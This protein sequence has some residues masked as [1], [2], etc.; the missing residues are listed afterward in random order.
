MI[1][2]RTQKKFLSPSQL[3]GFLNCNYH[4]VNNLRGIKKK[5]KTISIKTLFKR[6]LKHEKDYL[7][8]IKKDKKK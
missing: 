8:K 5:E 1:K 3:I 7:A 6:G 4:T 2:T